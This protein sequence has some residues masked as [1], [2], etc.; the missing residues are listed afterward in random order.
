M[1]KEIIAG[2]K[3]GAAHA[4]FTK[5][6]EEIASHEAYTGMPDL[7][8]E[9]GRIQWEAPS[10]RT[11]GQ[12]RYSHQ[13]RRDWWATQAAQVG[14]STSSS[15]WISRVAKMIH[16]TKTKPC[17]KCGQVMDLRYVYPRML[18]L[19]RIEKLPFCDE[20]F[21]LSSLE[22]VF[23]L[24]LRL[25][26]QY[27]DLAVK[28]AFPA[29]FKDQPPTAEANT[30]DG[31]IDWLERVLVP[32]E[33]SMLSPGAMSNAPDR[34]DGFH[35]F[36]RCCRA[37]ADKA[38]T[39]KN[40]RSYTTD[41]RVFEY[42]AAGDWIAA[43]R[44]MGLIRRDFRNETCK[45]GHSGPCQADHIG[46][47]SLGFKHSPNFQ[48]LCGS[49]NSG[50][51][52]RMT[53]SDVE[54][55]INQ[56]VEGAE[57]ISW[58]SRGA[59]DACKGRVNSAEH[60]LRLS[61]ILRDNR[62]SLMAALKVIAEAGHYGFLASLLELQHANF[63]VEFKDLRVEGHI[64]KWNKIEQ[65]PRVTLYAEVQK[66]RRSRIAFGELI[67]YFSKENRNAFIVSAPEIKASLRIVLAE[68]EAIKPQTQG[69][70]RALARAVAAKA[71]EEDSLFRA[72]YRDFE[73]FDF[74][75][76]GPA[77]TKL[78]AHMTLVGLCLADKWDDDR[79]MREARPAEDLR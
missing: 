61:K 16:P 4:A 9:D 74:G 55:L 48:L 46:P 28:K 75:V 73:K 66:A 11:S 45:N 38:R 54:W 19:K 60:A 70:D 52:N 1:T 20:G 13:R 64:T 42:W 77:K 12:F 17:K 72:V 68:I 23:S 22:D 3:G 36:N 33:P 2:F 26:E 24:C 14:V 67:S 57:V 5:Y 71:N 30:L 29:M 79:F 50:K 65:K 59:W 21:E 58:H 7:R 69:L 27:G 32:S 41:R 34:L 76:F 47:I 53:L 15:Q 8:Y 6:I 51:N 44:L 43:D 31:W 40:L 49:C 56:E 39:P 10:N 37:V 35:S 78:D 25:Y 63:D 62:H 18:L